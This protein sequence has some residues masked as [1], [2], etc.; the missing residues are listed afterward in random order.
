MRKL[1]IFLLTAI[2]YVFS[3][4]ASVTAPSPVNFKLKLDVNGVNNIYFTSDGVDGSLANNK[5]IFPLLT[6]STIDGVYTL[7][8]TIEGSVYFHWELADDDGAVIT[9]KFV[10]DDSLITDTQDRMLDETGGGVDMNYWVT[11]K[12]KNGKTIGSIQPDILSDISLDA[13]TITIF[14]KKSGV[15]EVGGYVSP[16]EIKMTI[17]APTWSDGNTTFIDAQ[18]RGY[19]VANLTYN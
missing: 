10:K 13:R 9:L 1:F 12:D 11:V 16:A 4:A 18:Y 3:L 19:I 7:D 15:T 17:K 2:T 5:F 8:T 6:G 14:S